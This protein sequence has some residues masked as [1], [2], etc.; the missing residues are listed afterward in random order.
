[1]FDIQLL[2][3]THLVDIY[4]YQINIFSNQIYELI[5]YNIL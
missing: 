4:V 5:Q 1:M 3:D 2:E